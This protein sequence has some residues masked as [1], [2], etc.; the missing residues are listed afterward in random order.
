MIRIAESRKMLRN[1]AVVSALA[2]IS[3]VGMS[4]GSA[5]AAVAAGSGYGYGGDYATITVGCPGPP[6][7]SP[8]GGFASSYQLVIT[9]GGTYSGVGAVYVGPTTVTITAD[10]HWIS[11][12]GTHPGSDCLVPG[13]IGV[14]AT[15]VGNA[16][17]GAVAC[18]TNSGSMIRV[19]EDMNIVFSGSCT[20]TGNQLLQTGTVISNM[21]QV[22]AGT[23]TPCDVPVP[24][25]AVTVHNPACDLPPYPQN[26]P[27]AIWAGSYTAAGT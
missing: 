10:P 6:T 8:I 1:R 24:P 2:V 12:L 27:G 25:T 14:T 23:L 21:Q 5:S 7:G 22:L 4:A 16:N 11:P 17:G 9:D 20:I 15:V 26:G 3:L 13:L 19:G 18:N